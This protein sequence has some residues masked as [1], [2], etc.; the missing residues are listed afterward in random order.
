MFECLFFTAKEPPSVSVSKT[1]LRDL[2]FELDLPPP[3]FTS[4]K[5]ADKRQKRAAVMVKVKIGDQTWTSFPA[6]FYVLEDA[7]EEAC[8]KAMKDLNAKKGLTSIFLFLIALFAHLSFHW[9]EMLKQ[10]TALVVK[11]EEKEELIANII[12]VNN[13]LTIY[14]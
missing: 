3:E 12:K 14:L 8:R 6:T 7:E 2:T 9:T 10:K 5:D 11:P 13:P 4:Y 1:V